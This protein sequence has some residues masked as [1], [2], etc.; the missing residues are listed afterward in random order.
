MP[1][2]AP[3]SSQYAMLPAGTKV[4]WGTPEALDAALKPLPNCTAVGKQGVTSGFVDCSTLLDTQE[5]SIADL[6]K[7][8]EKEFGFIDKPGDA[9]FQAFLDAAAA[10]Q[11][12]KVKIEMPNG[13]ISNSLI[14][15]AGWEMADIQAPANKVISILVKGKQNDIQWSMKSAS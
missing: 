10:R 7:G 9:D 14:S 13:R 6:P 11:T 12:V 5:Q 2:V 8:P 3:K 4:S 1:S 15:L